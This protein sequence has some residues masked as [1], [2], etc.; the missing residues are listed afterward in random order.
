MEKQVNNNFNVPN[1]A[2]QRTREQIAQKLAKLQVS[3]GVIA[4]KPLEQRLVDQMT[5]LSA[6][7]QALT[8]AVTA[9]TQAVQENTQAMTAPEEEEEVAQTGGLLGTATHDEPESPHL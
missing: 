1:P 6:Q 2:I 5:S 4:R 8:T 9:L 7:I 3:H